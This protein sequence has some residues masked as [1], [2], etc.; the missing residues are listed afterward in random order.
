VPWTFAQTLRGAALTLVP[1]LAFIVATQLGAPAGGAT[2]PLT[3]GQ[4]VTQ[5]ISALFV[6]ALLEGVFLIAPLYYALGR[7]SAVG[8]RAEGLRGLGFRPAPLSASLGLVVG[9][10][11]A[12]FMVSYLYGVIVERFHLPLRTNVEALQAQVHAEPVTVL[13]TLAGAVII[14]PICEEVFFRGYLFAGLLRGMEVWP[15]AL[16][17]ALLFVAA[18]GDLGSAVPLLALGLLLAALRWRTGSIWPSIAL[19]VGNNALASIYVT[20][21]LLGH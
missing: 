1:W 3:R 20:A 2:R 18:H 16:I 21:V 17:S 12:V 14:A 10:I 19:H 11:A 8:S 6:T 13:C 4:D 9:G 7:R 15:A 5:G